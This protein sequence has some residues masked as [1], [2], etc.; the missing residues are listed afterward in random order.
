MKFYIIKRF[1]ITDNE[2]NTTIEA[3]FDKSQEHDAKQYLINTIKH[4]LDNADVTNIVANL[5]DCKPSV[6]I[7][8]TQL[9]PED[10]DTQLY[11]TSKVEYILVTYNK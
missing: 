7:E 6:T 5:E 9:L 8:F 4:Y 3:D 2:W 1:C 11:A 10:N